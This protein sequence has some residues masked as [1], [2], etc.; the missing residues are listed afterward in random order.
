MVAAVAMAVATV[1]ATAAVAAAE[2]SVADQPP[3]PQ[4]SPLRSGFFA[5]QR[6]IPGQA[7]DDI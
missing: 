2:A 6:W 5:T 7:R 3:A 4:K 1:A